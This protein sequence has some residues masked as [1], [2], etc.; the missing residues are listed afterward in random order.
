MPFFR[1]SKSIYPIAIPKLDSV[2]ICE[3]CYCKDETFVGYRIVGSPLPRCR[4]CNRPYVLTEEQ[5]NVP[6]LPCIHLTHLEQ[7][8]DGFNKIIKELINTIAYLFEKQCKV[9]SDWHAYCLTKYQMEEPNSED[10][11]TLFDKTYKNFKIHFEVLGR[12]RR[13]IMDRYAKVS[14]IRERYRNSKTS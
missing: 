8:N 12:Q 10:V 3:D 4:C 14:D 5:T 6:P 2:E 13:K 7:T 1:M 11:R 9:W